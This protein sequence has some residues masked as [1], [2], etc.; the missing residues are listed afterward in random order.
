MS[1]TLEIVSYQSRA[2]GQNRYFSFGRDGG[3][4]GRS[5]EADWSLPDPQCYVSNRHASIDCRSGSW[6]VIDTSKN[7]VFVNGSTRPIGRDK[8]QRLFPGDRIR[9]GDYELSVAIEEDNS[10]HDEL[11]DRAHI[12][13]VDAA[14]RV[15]SPEKTDELLDALAITG[16]GYEIDFD[17]GGELELELEETH[18][19]AIAEVVAAPAL[20]AADLDAFFRG[21]NLETPRLTP[22]QTQQFMAELGSVTRELVTGVLECLHQRALQKAQ[23][24]ES[25]TIIEP[26]DNNRLKFAADFEEAFERLFFD[27]SEHFKSAIDSARDAM[28]DIRQH[29]RFLFTLPSARKAG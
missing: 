8:P 12:D 9:I 27:D 6:Y 18:T 4:I 10:L 23:L 3:T 29:Q 25:V 15:E 11:L 14:Q 19:Q 21:A 7:G 13:P 2:L 5:V 22:E 26:R 1:L 17:A 16:S 24:Q 20:G 28:K